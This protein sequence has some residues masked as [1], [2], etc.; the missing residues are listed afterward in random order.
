MSRRNLVRDPLG[1]DF[2]YLW[3][4]PSSFPGHDRGWL[5]HVQRREL[6]FG[7]GT[8]SQ[9]GYSLPVG[10]Q[11]VLVP[12]RHAPPGLLA[13]LPRFADLSAVRPW[14]LVGPR[15]TAY[16]NLIEYAIRDTSAFL[17]DREGGQEKEG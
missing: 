10:G 1:K 2:S 13:R 9:P 5:A 17:T 15:P 11:W 14:L 12:N 7:L 3:D 8:G 4:D 16:S 6:G